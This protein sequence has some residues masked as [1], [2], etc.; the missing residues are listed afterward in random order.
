MP[1][2]VAAELRNGRLCDTRT[3][4]G[5][6][7]TLTDANGNVTTYQ[8]DG[9]DRLTK[10]R[11]PN[12]TGGGSSTTDYV[13]ITDY[14][15]NFKPTIQTVRASPLAPITTT[16]DALNR[17]THVIYP[18]GSWADPNVDYGYDNLGRLV[19]GVATNGHTTAIGYDALGNKTSE[20][21]ALSTMTMQYDAAGR[22][23]RTT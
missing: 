3:P 14:D 13:A 23:T 22:R 15:A 6:T 9:Y 21:E 11:F 18:G 17:P 7:Q 1:E 16:Y 20:A 10:T 5:L 4:D 12:P 2:W 19:S 8:C